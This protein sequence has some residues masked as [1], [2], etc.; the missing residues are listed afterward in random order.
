IDLNL[1]TTQR[2]PLKWCLTI[3][4]IWSDLFLRRVSVFAMSLL[5]DLV[6]EDCKSRRSLKNKVKELIW[7][8]FPRGLDSQRRDK[9]INCSITDSNDPLLTWDDM[10]WIA[11]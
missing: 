2:P 8:N 6:Q 1:D 11:K 9:Y 5:G 4:N 7:C 10:L 3:A